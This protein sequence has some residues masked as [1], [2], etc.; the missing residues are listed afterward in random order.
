MLNLPFTGLRTKRRQ[1][2][3]AV[4][5][6][7]TELK[8]PTSGCLVRQSKGQKPPKFELPRPMKER[9]RTPISGQSTAKFVI[10]RKS[11]EVGNKRQKEFVHKKS[12]VSIP[13]ILLFCLSAIFTASSITKASH[14][15]HG[16]KKCSAYHQ[17]CIQRYEGIWLERQLQR[18]NSLGTQFVARSSM[19]DA[20]STSILRG[21]PFGGVSIGLSPKS[22]LFFSVSRIVPFFMFGIKSLFLKVGMYD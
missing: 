20:I 9:L 3:S 19:E 12:F 7:N 2:P 6:T 5:Y 17:S 18:L 4:I 1:I 14:N 16:F 8:S 10:G 22:I 11:R 15:L 13:T 21:R